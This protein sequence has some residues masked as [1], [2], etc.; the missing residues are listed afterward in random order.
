MKVAII[1]AGNVGKALATSIS[2]AGH[3][4]TISASTP[5]S[6]LEAA[7]AV[8]V[9]AAESNVDA[10]QQAGVIILA[11]PYVGA[12]PEV[13]QEI[14]DAVAGKTVVDATNPLKP[15][16]SG[17]ATSGTSAAEEFQKLL[18]D[19]RVVKAFNTIFAA[20]QASP[21]P[22]VDAYVAGDDGEAKRQVIG[23]AESLGFTPLDVGPLSAARTLEGMAYVNIGLNA[24]NGWSWTSAWKL[25]R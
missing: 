9:T 14:R 19:A 22:E 15:D 13:A 1:G 10:A 4:V 24:A 21:S 6:A 18:P 17:L 5:E 25:E 16:Y 23:L 11:V 3:E 20:N 8:G 12:G 7:D 2:R